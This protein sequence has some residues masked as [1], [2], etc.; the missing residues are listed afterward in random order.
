M[1][2]KS[3]AKFICLLH[4]CSTRSKKKKKK[5][6]TAKK[7]S[8]NCPGQFA[9]EVVREVSTF[10][11]TWYMAHYFRVKGYHIHVRLLMTLDL[12]QLTA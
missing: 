8:E 4:P 1:D 12:S 11:S 7:W 2:F 10:T 3:S 5:K 9:D 6:I